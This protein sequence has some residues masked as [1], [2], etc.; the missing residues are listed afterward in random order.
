[1][2]VGIDQ[3]GI[4]E[5]DRFAY[6]KPERLDDAIRNIPSY[7]YKTTSQ[8]GGKDLT[9][10]YSYKSP[11]EIYNAVLNTGITYTDMADTYSKQSIAEQT[12]F[13]GT[14]ATL[15][16]RMN[17]QLKNMNDF[18]VKSGAGEILSLFQK[19]DNKVG[20][21]VNNPFEYALYQKLFSNMPK[22]LGNS[23]D[24]KS[25]NH[26]LAVEQ[27]NMQKEN[28]VWKRAQET[29]LDGLIIQDVKD[30]KFNPIDW[31][32]VINAFVSQ[33][34]ST[35]GNIKTG[36]VSF[37]QDGNSMI[38]TTFKPLY[39]P[40]GTIVTDRNA[41][42]RILKEGKGQGSGRAAAVTAL[43]GGLGYGAKEITTIDIDK[44]RS[45]WE[46]RIVNGMNILGESIINDTTKK[47]FEQARKNT[48][49]N[50]IE[51]LSQ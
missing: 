4:N 51:E 38:V 1:M 48:S 26:Y 33:Q 10:Y 44:T 36:E 5:L 23:Y 16:Q 40:D 24:Y 19:N 12:L 49:K 9:R 18:Y 11:N 25:S 17:K 6:Y 2:Q 42:D 27:L 46:T 21:D 22:D 39:N 3:L 14:D 34:E 31:E 37:S 35:L 41:A 30:G 13:A 43:P 15:E 8:S 7:N 28:Q 20:V 45:G 50:L 47:S 29:S 32:N